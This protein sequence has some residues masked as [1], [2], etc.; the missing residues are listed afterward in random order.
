MQ[1]CLSLQS[2][3]SIPFHLL[4]QLLSITEHFFILLN[5]FFNFSLGCLASTSTFTNLYRSPA[6][7]ALLYS[8]T[9]SIPKA[10]Q[11]SAHSRNARPQQTQTKQSIYTTPALR[12]EEKHCTASFQKEHSVEMNTQ[13]P[14]CSLSMLRKCSVHSSGIHDITV[15]EIQGNLSSRQNLNTIEMNFLK[16]ETGKEE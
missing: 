11:I 8:F 10:E 9:Q 1:P 6:N 7:A 15:S 2:R 12:W 4:L 5:F 3:Q 16:T 13:T 14:T